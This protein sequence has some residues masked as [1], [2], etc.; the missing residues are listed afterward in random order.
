M[1]LTL[2]YQTWKI[3]RTLWKSVTDQLGT[4]FFHWETTISCRGRSSRISK[5]KTC[6]DGKWCPSQDIKH[7]IWG[8]AIEINFQD[9]P[10]TKKVTVPTAVHLFP[11][12]CYHGF[13]EASWWWNDDI[14]NVRCCTPWGCPKIYVARKES[15]G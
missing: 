13:T 8:D 9:H 2:P 5:S 11:V 1:I 4:T 14:V 10:S 12:L 15:M 6:H 7:D 3:S